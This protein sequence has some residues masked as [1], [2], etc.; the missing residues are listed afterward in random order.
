MIAVI[1]GLIFLNQDYSKP[2][3]I[4]N[5]NGV[6]F[7]LITNSSFSFLFAVINSF[8]PEIPIFLREHYNGLY[9][10]LA[11]YLSKLMIEV[12]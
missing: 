11:Y 6:C 7:L 10:V 8:P 9:R 1:F 2:G 4:Q 12:K 5:V 3:V